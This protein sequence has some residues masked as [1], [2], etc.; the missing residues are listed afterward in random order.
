MKPSYVQYVKLPKK[1]RII[2]ISDIHGNYDGFV[3]L[4]RKI[5]YKRRD[6]LIIDGDITEKGPESLKT[7]TFIMMLAKHNT[8]YFTKGNCDELF[9]RDFADESQLQIM[10]RYIRS[11]PNSLW[12]EMASILNLSLETIDDFKKAIPLIH[13]RFKTELDFLDSFPVILETPH[14]TFVHAGLNDKDLTKIN[15][16]FCIK[17]DSF[18]TLNKTT[19]DKWVVVGHWP[20]CNYGDILDCNPK[21][22]YKRRVISID[23]A[24]MVKKF[25]QLNALIIS[26]TESFKI[27]YVSYENSP[28][29]IIKRDQKGGRRPIPLDYGD[30]EMIILGDK[31]NNLWR[32]KQVSTGYVFALPKNKLYPRGDKWYCVDRTDY[33][34]PLK[35]NDQVYVYET[36]PNRYLVKKDGV[37]GWYAE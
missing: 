16:K 18:M 24:N 10:Y 6:I 28:T 9:Y 37:I 29:M 34:L 17:N 33:F 2:V 11:M 4:L 8:V 15:P 26:G 14:M 35:K 1:R 32:V 7:L 5:A 19:F 12:H 30:N 27:D 25:G 22:D 31:G 36:L 3:S 20:V 21:I 23:G 13:K